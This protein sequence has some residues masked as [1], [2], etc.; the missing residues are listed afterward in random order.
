MRIRCGP[1]V[2]SRT[3]IGVRPTSRLST[4]N[5]APEG[6]ERTFRRPSAH[7]ALAGGA[8]ASLAGRVGAGV[9]A[10]TAL[11]GSAGTVGP[12]A[13]AAA[14]GAGAGSAASAG[15]DGVA[16]VPS[17]NSRPGV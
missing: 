3:D 8:A 12:G 7:A 13:A 16:T 2:R 1:S 4:V 17:V 5:R 9:G 11:G 15:F 10:G 14:A 6:V